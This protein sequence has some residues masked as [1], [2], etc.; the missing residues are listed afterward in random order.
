M[1]ETIEKD[2]IHPITRGIKN[3]FIRILYQE[4]NLSI[5][6]ESLSHQIILVIFTILNIKRLVSVQKNL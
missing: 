5:K 6:L 1:N 4:K 3:Q 2:L